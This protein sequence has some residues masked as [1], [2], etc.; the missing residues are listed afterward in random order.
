[1]ARIN[2]E[3]AAELKKYGAGDFN[4]CF[5]CG[6][7]TATCSLST[8]ENSFPREMIRCSSLGLEEDITSSLKPWMCYYCGECTT[9]CPRTANPGEL[10][11]SLRRWLMA[12]YDWTGLSGILYKS[13]TITITAM[14][15]VAVGVVW[16]AA[17]NAFNLEKV[18]HFGHMFEMLAIAGVFTIILIP[19]I[20]RMWY[21]TIIKP[22]KNVSFKKYVTSL[23]EFFIHMFTQKRALGCDDNQTRWFEHFILVI[24]Y[25]T[26]FFITVFLDWFGSDS[27]F[28]IALGYVASTIIFVVTFDFVL[29]RI[30]KSKEVS[31]NSQP[32]DWF[33]VIWLLLM[34]FSAF[35][36]RTFIDLDI[37]E[38]NKWLYLVH[39]IVLAQWALLIVPFGKWSHFLYR[40]FAMY[41]AKLITIEKR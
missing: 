31:K 18:M 17:C 28:V 36:V 27:M 8:E 4:A 14:I 12:K 40:S 39:L 41:F 5:N 7:C 33:F 34:G 26:L 29:G 38:N 20:I 15:L 21:F 30:K 10:M 25:L 22:D 37:L 6:T 9:H 2:P 19:N 32:S 13:M 1:M 11:M 23:G 24:G 16:F 35:A 3:F